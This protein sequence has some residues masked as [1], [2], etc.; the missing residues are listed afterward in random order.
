VHAASSACTHVHVRV[1][2]ATRSRGSMHAN[3]HGNELGDWKR[4]TQRARCTASQ[5][6]CSLRPKIIAHLGGGGAAALRAAQVAA[7]VM[8]NCTSLH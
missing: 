6:Y 4:S 7:L 1:L 8:V 2:Y 3:R 5:M